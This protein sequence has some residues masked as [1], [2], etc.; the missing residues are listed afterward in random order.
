MERNE[1]KLDNYFSDKRFSNG[2]NSENH[3]SSFFCR[4]RYQESQIKV[5]GRFR[6]DNPQ[7][8]WHAYLGTRGRQ[9]LFDLTDLT[10][11]HLKIADSRV[12]NLYHSPT[13]N[14]YVQGLSV[15]YTDIHV[16]YFYF[17][18]VVE[19][20]VTNQFF[21]F[22]R[23]FLDYLME[24]FLNIVL[25]YSDGT[26]TAL[27]ELPHTDFEASVETSDGSLLILESD[28]FSS[29]TFRYLV[30]DES[31]EGT[32]RVKVAGS[33]RCL[34]ESSTGEENSLGRASVI[35]RPQKRSA[36]VRANDA[37]DP[38]K[39]ISSS[40]A[41][42]YGLS[43][44]HKRL[45]AISLDQNRLQSDKSSMNS[46]V[47][48]E[49]AANYSRPPE[50]VMYCMIA[51]CA[52][53]GAIFSLNCLVRSTGPKLAVLSPSCFR[54]TNLTSTS[55]LFSIFRRDEV[56]P[57]GEEFIWVKAD[58]FSRPNAHSFNQTNGRSSDNGGGACSTNLGNSCSHATTE[59]KHGRRAGGSYMGSEVSIHM[60]DHPVIEVH[61]DGRRASSWNIA[62]SRSRPHALVDSSSERNISQYTSNPSTELHWNSRSLGLN[63]VQLQNFINSLRETIT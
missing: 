58:R 5:F 62:R 34:L 18:K 61:E 9:V 54:V 50:I 39:R 24:C 27:S 14:V 6:V 57:A 13:G 56:M 17:S 15:G 42:T 16:S 20:Y 52:I 38:S 46:D 51:V 59:R 31:R 40:F 26:K 37:D 41:G 36:M 25:E 29:A 48:S 7:S 4:S 44:M 30:M 22:F 63:E 47:H 55:A 33:H 12:A 11:E 8:G 43:G 53:V 28:S 60:S 45:K 49:S 21:R 35:V 23:H 32:I 1:H 3:Q 19:S 10:K 2:T